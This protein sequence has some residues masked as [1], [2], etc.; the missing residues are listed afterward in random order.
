MSKLIWLAM[1][2]FYF[3]LILGIKLISFVCDFVY[4]SLVSYLHCPTPQWET[5]AIEH[6]YKRFQFLLTSLI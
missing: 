6:I 4:S 2:F 3:F 5:E 1:F